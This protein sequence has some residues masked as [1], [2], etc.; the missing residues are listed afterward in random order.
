MNYLS[1]L[2]LFLFMIPMIL[3]FGLLG[4]VTSGSEKTFD[5]FVKTVYVYAI[6]LPISAGIIWVTVSDEFIH[7]HHRQLGQ[8]SMSPMISM[9]LFYSV[10]YA[11]KARNAASCIS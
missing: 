4:C 1:F 7:E 6:L 5:V 10:K 3:V 8:L 9:L 11:K 2:N